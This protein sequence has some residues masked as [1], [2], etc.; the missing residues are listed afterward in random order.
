MSEEKDLVD[1]EK[2][3]LPHNLNFKKFLEDVT[4]EDVEIELDASVP[5]IIIML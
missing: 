3:P 2:G 5:L 1:F 4:T